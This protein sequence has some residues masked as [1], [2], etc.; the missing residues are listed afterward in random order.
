MAG[1]SLQSAAQPVQI[2]PVMEIMEMSP[3]KP[4]RLARE[5]FDKFQCERDTQKDGKKHSGSRTKWKRW[6][7]NRKTV[8]EDKTPQVLRVKRC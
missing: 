4:V 8:R 6:Q 5:L 3:E 2:F 1:K 7:G